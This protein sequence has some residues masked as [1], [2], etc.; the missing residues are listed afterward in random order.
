MPLLEVFQRSSVER[1]MRRKDKSHLKSSRLTAII[2]ILVNVII[3]T[4]FVVRSDTK[5]GIA[6]ENSVT[7]QVILRESQSNYILLVGSVAKMQITLSEY[8]KHHDNY[9]NE[10][11]VKMKNIKIEIKTMQ[12]FIEDEFF[13]GK[14]IFRGKL[15]SANRAKNFRSLTQSGRN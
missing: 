9:T 14:D 11:N 10:S 5:G 8:I 3:L 15:E 4:A 6:L 13:G 12:N 1:M 2:G 7:N